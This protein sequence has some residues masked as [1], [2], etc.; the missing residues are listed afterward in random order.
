MR[1]VTSFPN[2]F[3]LEEFAGSVQILHEITENCCRREVACRNLLGRGY[4]FAPLLVIII[5]FCLRQFADA[6]EPCKVEWVSILAKE[7]AGSVC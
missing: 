6:R 3:D 1:Y 5:T 4:G 2:W 7:A